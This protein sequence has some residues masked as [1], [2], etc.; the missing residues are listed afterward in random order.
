MNG[1]NKYFNI[2]CDQKK[3]FSYSHWISYVSFFFSHSI[4]VFLQMLSKIDSWKRLASAVRNKCFCQE[5]EMMLLGF[6][7]HFSSSKV[8]DSAQ[9]LRQ[10]SR[11]WTTC[12]LEDLRS[13][14]CYSQVLSRSIY[15]SVGLFA[16]PLE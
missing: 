16:G 12:G 6:S 4:L 13:R 7:R 3:K 1:S 5:C 10:S 2:K 8:P 11:L 9:S 14:S 15:F